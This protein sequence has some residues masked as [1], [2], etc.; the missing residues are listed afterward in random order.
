MLKNGQTYFKNL[1]MPAQD[2]QSLFDFF[3]YYTPK[4]L[5]YESVLRH[6]SCYYKY[7]QYFLMKQ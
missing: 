4:D 1:V 3:R 6:E 2:F 7:I 5:A